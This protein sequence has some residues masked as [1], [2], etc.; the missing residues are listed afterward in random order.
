MV[1]GCAQIKST[2]TVQILPKQGA[3]AVMIGGPS[4]QITARGAEVQ[5]EQHA[6]T[7]EV[8]VTETR[9]CREVRHHPVVRVEH[10]DRKPGAALYWEYGVGAAVLAFGLAALIRPEFLSP[11]AI[12][13]AGERV[14]DVRTGY[15][16]GGLFTALGAAFIVA[17]VIDSVRARDTTYHADAYRLEF[18]DRI[19]CAAPRVPMREARVE[20]IVD[21]WRDSAL[22]DD[23][24]KV[25]FAL[26]RALDVDVAAEPEPPPAAAETAGEG[27]GMPDVSA[28]PA[29]DGHDV[30]RGVIRLDPRRATAF[31][32]AVPFASSAAS[33]YA[34][35]ATLPALT[36]RG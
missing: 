8:R 1:G 13:P 7:L 30:R 6:S 4:G 31:D 33:G 21:E 3:H 2:S 25:T 16:V 27:R 17:G 14:R 18:G 11:E 36:P 19:D 9:L 28:V 32:F 26:P 15:R 20:V 23:D 12:N 29:L 34:G 22:T 10:V 35:A 5:W 24:G